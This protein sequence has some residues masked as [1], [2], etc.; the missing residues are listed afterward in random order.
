MAPGKGM[1]GRR[2]LTGIKGTEC[3]LRFPSVLPLGLDEMKRILAAHLGHGAGIM[4]KTVAR[5]NG[6]LSVT[7]HCRFL[8]P[9]QN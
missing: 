1:L 3:F 6:G 5:C 2:R 4:V 7:L 8:I 9:S